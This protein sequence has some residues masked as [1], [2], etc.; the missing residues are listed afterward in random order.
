MLNG[1]ESLSVTR[2]HRQ[3][4]KAERIPVEENSGI[5]E[6]STRMHVS[7]RNGSTELVDVAKIVRAVS[8]CCEGLPEVDANRVAIKTIS[9]LYDGASTKEL[10]QLSIQTSATLIAEEP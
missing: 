9:G 7:K 6:A 1:I 3:S 5:H 4:P 2:P 10:D 8:R